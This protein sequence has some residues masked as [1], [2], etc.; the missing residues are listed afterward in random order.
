MNE[1]CTVGLQLLLNTN[2]DMAPCNTLWWLWL[3]VGALEPIRLS[4]RKWRYAWFCLTW[5]EVIDVELGFSF[6]YA[7]MEK[8]LE[9][10][11]HALVLMFLT[12]KPSFNVLRSEI[13]KSCGFA[14]TL[15]I[16]FMDFFHVLVHL[17]NDQDYL[18]TWTRERRIVASCK[19]WLFNSLDFDICKEPSIAAQWI[20]LPS[21]PLVLYRLDCLQIL[22][23]LFDKFLG[24]NNFWVFR[25]FIEQELLELAFVL[26]WTC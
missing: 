7:K 17:K 5:V 8:A 14:V 2:I 18:H 6:S 11:K 26:W 21:L 1:T 22:T 20:F 19:L 4:R 15:T 24:T 3:Q 12:C 16:N 9:D 13:L 25:P 23:T 10:F